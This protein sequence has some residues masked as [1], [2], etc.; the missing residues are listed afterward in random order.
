MLIEEMK[1]VGFLE[2]ETRNR[3]TRERTHN[4]VLLVW[5]IIASDEELINCSVPWIRL[6]FIGPFKKLRRKIIPRAWK[7][8]TLD[9]SEREIERE[10]KTNETG[11]S[12]NR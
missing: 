5:P 8:Q 2:K 6:F 1:F 11:S 9:E 7:E 10:G 4:F 12:L 3:K